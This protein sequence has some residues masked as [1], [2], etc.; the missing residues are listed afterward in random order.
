VSFD[1]LVFW[2]TSII[3]DFLILKIQQKYSSVL[4][5]TILLMN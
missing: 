1:F 4:L 2:N 5:N 3:L